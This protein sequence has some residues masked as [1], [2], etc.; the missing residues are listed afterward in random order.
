MSGSSGTRVDQSRA[1]RSRDVGAGTPHCRGSTLRLVAANECDGSGAVPAPDAA[2]P[3]AGSGCPRR[4][5]TG[6]HAKRVRA[7]TVLA[8]AGTLVS[9]AAS[10]GHRRRAVSM[11]AISV[12]ALAPRLRSTRWN[13]RVCV[14]RKRAATDIMSD[15]RI[16]TRRFLP[17]RPRASRASLY[18]ISPQDVGGGF[19]RPA[20]GGAGAGR[21]RRRSSCG[22]RTSRA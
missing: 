11:A 14:E 2:G 13:R 6:R 8:E 20:E 16:C 10:A 19:P 1:D 5:E 3:S 7:A 17:S 21:R 12:R 18:L 9:L 15:A 4:F 22:S